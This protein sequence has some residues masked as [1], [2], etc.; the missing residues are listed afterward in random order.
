MIGRE[1][2]IVTVRRQGG[3]AKG[4]GVEGFRQRVR[5]RGGRL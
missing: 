4:N 1:R 2:A 3:A 5:L